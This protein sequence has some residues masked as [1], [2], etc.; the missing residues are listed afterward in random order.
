MCL[1]SIVSSVRAVQ[2]SDTSQSRYVR[3]TVYSAAATGIFGEA[4]ELAVGLLQD[5]FG[6]AGRLN[7]GPQLLDFLRLVVVFTQFALDGLELFAQEVFALVLADLGLHLRLD[8]RSKFQD[9]QFLDQQPVEQVHARAHVERVE[10][11]L[12]RG[13]GDGRQAR[14]DEVG[15]L[16]GLGDVHRERLQVVG[17]QRRQRHHL[18]EVRLDV[19]LQRVDFEAVFVAGDFFR[20]LDFGQQIR[21]ARRELLQRHARQALDDQAQAAVG[22]LEHL[23]DVRGRADAIEI[24]LGGLFDRRITLGEDGDQLGAV[25]RLVD[26]AHRCLPRD[27]ERHER[28]RKEHRVSERKDRQLGW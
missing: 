17:Q 5:G 18:L 15:E 7:L 21:L 9:F 27:R 1:R 11:F 14:D 2:G 4:I 16:A 8:L 10:H 26:E 20:F 12:L 13:R 3:D 23:V 25:H 6:H 22:Q 24:F 28:I 19:A